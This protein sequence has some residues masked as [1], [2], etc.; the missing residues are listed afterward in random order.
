MD[1]QIACDIFFDQLPG[2][3]NSSPL[4]PED[5]CLLQ[6][7]FEP[8]LVPRSA[9]EFRLPQV[10]IVVCYVRNFSCSWTKSLSAHQTV[11]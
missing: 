1:L 6:L 11:G 10:A 9:L 3:G 7:S 2:T 5:V 8:Q 4:D